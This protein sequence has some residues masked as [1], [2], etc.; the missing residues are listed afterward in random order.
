MKEWFDWAQVHNTNTTNTALEELLVENTKL[1]FANGNIIPESYAPQQ[2]SEAIMIW[3]L[4]DMGHP[5]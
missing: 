2:G 3:F 4:A 1:M 5:D